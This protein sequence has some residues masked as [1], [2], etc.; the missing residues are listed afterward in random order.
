MHIL[1]IRI[2]YIYVNQSNSK[3]YDVYI[4]LDGYNENMKTIGIITIF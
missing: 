1:Y 4:I 3:I 2:I